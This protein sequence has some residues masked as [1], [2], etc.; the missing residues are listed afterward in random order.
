MFGREGEV[1]EGFGLPHNGHAGPQAAWFRFNVASRSAMGRAAGLLEQFVEA[2][3]HVDEEDDEQDDD[4][5][6]EAAGE[7]P[8]HERLR[9]GCIT[10]PDLNAARLSAG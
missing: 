2:H 8:L 4:G 1:V 9:A 10:P 5:D 6:V 7:E 3:G